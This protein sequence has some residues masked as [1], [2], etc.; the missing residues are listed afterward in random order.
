MDALRENAEAAEAGLASLGVSVDP[1][2]WSAT[3]DIP[4]LN[5][6]EYDTIA[7]AK[8]EI[9]YLN[10]KVTGLEAEV[11]ETA[12]EKAAALAELEVLRKECQNCGPRCRDGS[13][14]PRNKDDG[15]SSASAGCSTHVVLAAG[16]S[17][18]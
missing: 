14:P 6:A 13:K 2:A 15:G 4:N 5:G 10:L 9:D 11:R 16:F 12:E 3:R 7:Y 8:A 17:Q 1:L 18:I